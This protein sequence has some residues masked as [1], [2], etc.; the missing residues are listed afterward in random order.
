MATDT[1]EILTAK[2][3]GKI[4]VLYERCKL[5]GSK[6]ACTTAGQM[7]GMITTKMLKGRI[8]Y[9]LPNG[10]T[11]KLVGTELEPEAGTLFAEFSC[12]GFVSLVRV[13][14]CA[15]GKALPINVS[16]TMGQL[17]FEENTAKFGQRFVEIEGGTHAPCEL[18]VSALA[19]AAFGRGWL[20]DSELE[21]FNEAVELKA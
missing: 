5:Q 16:S 3:V 18:T 12:E 17:V 13:E 11:E 14:G 20:M 6:S 21:T 15:I 8:G 7:E 19:G 4:S 2:T 10:K 9:V 1:G